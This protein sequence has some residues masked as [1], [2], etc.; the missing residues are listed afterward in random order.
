MLLTTQSWFRSM[1]MIHTSSNDAS[2]NYP[3]YKKLTKTYKSEGMLYNTKY[4]IEEDEKRRTLEIIDALGFDVALEA[5]YNKALKILEKN[6]DMASANIWLAW[7][8]NLNNDGKRC[9][10]AHQQETLFSIAKFYRKLAH[11]IYWHQR[12]HGTIGFIRD[13]LQEVPT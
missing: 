6:P 11:K 7:S 4:K 13:F 3:R 5:A 1:V 8:Y 2:I 9:A 12:K 10:S